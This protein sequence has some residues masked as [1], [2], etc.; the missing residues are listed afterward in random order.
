VSPILSSEG[1]PLGAILVFHDVTGARELE[2]TVSYQAIHDALTGL[3]NRTEFE[4][5][6][7]SSIA[8][9]E[10][11]SECHVVCVVD[12]DQLR[13]INETCTQESGDNLLR[14][15]AGLLQDTLHDSGMAARLGGD[16]FGF[17]LR[18]CSVEHAEQVAESLLAKIHSMRF[19]GCGRIIEVS[20]SIG[21]AAIR[22]D[23]ENA[24]H[25]MSEAELACQKAGESGGNRFHTY[26]STD[27]V[28]VNH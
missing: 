18:N 6:M 28:L 9:L 23:C 1:S 4:R 10:Q 19:T 2:R 26:L 16:E 3:L 20:A 11:P 15:V 24:G 17:L 7:E 25:V 8:G 14:N 12:I 21:I 13:I 5:Q 22:P 27:A